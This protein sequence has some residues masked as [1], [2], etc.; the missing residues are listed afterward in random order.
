MPNDQR[1][2]EIKERIAIT[3]RRNSDRGFIPYG[4]CNRICGEMLAIIEEAEK[5][6]DQKL[7]FDIFMAILLQIMKLISR[8]DTSS[9]LATDVID[10]CLRDTE[11]LCR[12]AVA[13]DWKYFFDTIIKTAKSKAFRD[14]PENGYG[15]LKSAVHFI[16]NQDEAQKILDVFPLLETSYS[17]SP[18]PDQLLIEFEIIERLEG[19]EA[20]DQYL[21]AHIDLPE[22][23]MLAVDRA[24]AAKHYLR[25]EKLCREALKEDIR[26]YFNQRPPWAY[27]LERLYRETNQW[28][29]LLETVR[30]LL[31]QRDISY[32]QKL[33]DIYVR[34][35]IWEER[36]EPLWRELSKKLPDHEYAGLLAQEGEAAKL[37]DVVK[38]HPIY[39]FQYGKQLASSYPTET[40]AMYEAR[41]LEEAGEATDRRKYRQVCR[42]IKDF[43]AAGTKGKAVE[44]INR[45]AAMYPRRPAMLEELLKTK[46]KLEK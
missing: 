39:V 17:G 30:L 21:T 20:A 22:M 29:K 41:L 13:A 8:A 6:P 10:F 44:L 42:K 3:I 40:Y 27:Y 19:A 14:W 7:A 12:T 9:G 46:N 25:V 24:F 31:F 43:A 38:D 1:L 18:Y 34:Q 37:L 33:K 23:R 2:T 28:D 26:G 5:C 15:L 4:G 45:L 35:G 36:R 11:K 16:R 32:F